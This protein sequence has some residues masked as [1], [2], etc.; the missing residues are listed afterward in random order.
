[1]AAPHHYDIIILGS[2]L[3]GLAMARALPTHLRARTLLIDSQ[4]KPEHDTSLGQGARTTA[5][6]RRTL[7]ILAQWGC[8]DDLGGGL[9]RSIEVSQQGYWGLSRIDAKT[10]EPTLGQVVTNHRLYHALYERVSAETA[11]QFRYETEIQSIRF[12]ADAVHIELNDGTPIQ[13]ALLILADGGASPWGG[14]CGLH[15]QTKDYDQV[16]FALNIERDQPT[17]QTAYERFTVQGSRALLPLGEHWQTVV[18]VAPAD[19][20]LA[21][22]TWGPE[23]WTGAIDQC[24]GY[25]DGRIVHCS[26]A[27]SYPLRSRTVSEQARRRLA[28]V[29]NGALTL[30]PIAGQGFNLHCRTVFELGQILAQATDP[31]DFKLLQQW[32]QRVQP[33]QQQIAKGCDGLLT[34]FK[35]WHPAFAH[36][37]G[38][39][40][41]AF[42]GLPWAA[43]WLAQRAMGYRT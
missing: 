7:D 14:R 18:W 38:L 2:G 39:G 33:D 9:I 13:T 20:A 4:A 30:H 25:Q 32:Q 16:A 27:G 19:Q 12:S 40:L 3:V 42:N 37:R 15:W 23:E 35:P 11:P 1:M 41:Q 10:D 21:L 26:P 36:A 31:G 24:F 5:L 17:S 34:L 28:V 43:S 29:G 22:A 6:N 8:H